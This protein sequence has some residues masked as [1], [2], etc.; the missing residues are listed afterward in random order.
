MIHGFS[1]WREGGLLLF[2]VRSLAL[3]LAV[4][5]FFI[6]YNS[7][8]FLVHSFIV[9][10]VVSA[11]TIARLIYPFHWY[12]R[13]HS[14]YLLISS[15]VIICCTLPF[16]TGG[17][18]SPFILYPLTA[19]LSASLS[20]ELQAAWRGGKIFGIAADR[21]GDVWLMSQAG[22]LVVSHRPANP[23]SAGYWKKRQIPD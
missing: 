18:N 10:G 2:I 8:P 1:R 16:V 5:Q 23:R 6:F 15:D 3:S 4:A 19:I 13:K 9:I 21:D 17:F 22:E 12:G 20:P 7:S 14:S 11:Y